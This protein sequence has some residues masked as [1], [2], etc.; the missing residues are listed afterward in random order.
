MALPA[1]RAA[2]LARKIN[3]LQLWTIYGWPKLLFQKSG[4]ATF[5]HAV[6]AGLHTCGPALR[7]LK[8]HV[9]FT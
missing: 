2:D 9:F 4:G 7:L 5:E 3:S 8:R 1:R 6:S